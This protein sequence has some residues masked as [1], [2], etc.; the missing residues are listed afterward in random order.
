MKGLLRKEL[1]MLRNTFYILMAFVAIYA[2]FGYL[3]GTSSMVIAVFAVMTMMLPANSIIYDEL[4]HWDRYVLTAPVSRRMLVQSKYALCLLLAG[5]M[6]LAGVVFQLLVGSSLEDAFFT[7]LCLASGALTI[8]AL[9]LPFSFRW[10]AQRGRLI[11]M[12]ICGAVGALFAILAIRFESGAAV[13]PPVFHEAAFSGVLLFGM[14]AAA[15]VLITG[16][17]YWASCRIYQRK[18]F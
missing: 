4:Y 1:Y 2:V 9:A 14:V 15:A 11:L 18:E 13:L 7:A 3:G 8:S 5:V 17:S 10:G 12:G 16:V 6:L